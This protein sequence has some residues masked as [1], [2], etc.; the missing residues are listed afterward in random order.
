M[1]Y[2]VIDSTI[3]NYRQY[4][5]GI[6]NRQTEEIQ[7]IIPKKYIN[8]DTIKLNLIK[9]DIND[10][11]EI[12]LNLITKRE[13]NLNERFCQLDINDFL[14]P[15]LSHQYLIF[16]NKTEKLKNDMKNKHRIRINNLK[17]IENNKFN[18]QALKEYQKLHINS[19]NKLLKNA[20]SY[21]LIR[22]RQD[23]IKSLICKDNSDI[24]LKKYSKKDMIKKAKELLEKNKLNISNEQQNNNNNRDEEKKEDEMEEDKDED[25]LITSDNII[26]K[27]ENHELIDHF[28]FLHF[29]PSK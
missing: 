12:F 19:N 2:K 20:P 24:N 8:H 10:Q 27:L 6:Q 17:T 26:T 21:K 22:S 18:E 3:E 14:S 9:N 5:I 13:N 1:M 4:I 15:D 29:K 23:T 28:K 16:H 7:S 11:I 25:Y